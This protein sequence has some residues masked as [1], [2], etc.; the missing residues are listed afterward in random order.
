MS[1]SER[2]IIEGKTSI[3]PMTSLD[4]GIQYTGVSS[5]DPVADQLVAR[6]SGR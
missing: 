4:V 3:N 2:D 5:Y 6:A 1:S